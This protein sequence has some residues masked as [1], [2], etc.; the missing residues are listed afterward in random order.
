MAFPE[1]R[2]RRMRR[3]PTLRRMVRETQ[4]SVDDLIMPFFVRH[5]ADVKLEIK[6]M[7]GNYQWSPDTLAE[8][9]KRAEGLG[10][11][12]IILFGIPETK[13]AQGSEAYAEDGIIP[14]AIEAVKEA[15]PS[16]CVITDVCMCEYTDHGHCGVIGE[17]RDGNPDVDNDATLELLVKEALAHVNAGADMVAPS[18][19]MDG[20]VNV[21]RIAL[22][23]E[24]FIDISIMA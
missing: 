13:D 17:N 6:S 22:A 19:M 14:R 3:N 2:L 21:I 5:G 24:G 9:A 11:P 18:D 10:I 16:L 7:P 23:G 20:R 4:L 8:E 15:A 12:G 1:T